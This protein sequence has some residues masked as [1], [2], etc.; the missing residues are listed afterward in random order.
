ME[1]V[2]GYIGYHRLKLFSAQ[3]TVRWYPE[4][5]GRWGGQ[6]G[7]KVSSLIV[8]TIKVKKK[9]FLLTIQY[10]FRFHFI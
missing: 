1:F 10:M 2:E 8:S 3:T 7:E 5:K 6:R 9:L 4:G